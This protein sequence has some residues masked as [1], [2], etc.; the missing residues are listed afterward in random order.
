MV[1]VSEA[2]R[3]MTGIRV[4]SVGIFDENESEFVAAPDVERVALELI[5]RCPELSEL[6]EAAFR[7]AWKREGGK[8]GE[9]GHCKKLSPETQ[10]LAGVQ[11]FV[12]LAADR[13]RELSQ[14]QIEAL[15]Y[16]ELNH[17]GF[18][19]KGKAIARKHDVE[20]FLG[21]IRR[22]GDWH[23]GLREARLA[24]EQLALPL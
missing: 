13:A 21:E 10:F 24:F 17:A 16:H 7:F 20:L 14:R 15:I 18:N 8:D 11:F 19:D 5:A 12:W 9:A 23:E 1:L 6:E 3:I 22:Y 2:E 4:P